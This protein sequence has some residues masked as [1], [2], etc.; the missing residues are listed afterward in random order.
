MYVW[1]WKRPRHRFTVEA[2]TGAASSRGTLL[3]AALLGSDS[4]AAE[5][6]VEEPKPASN[7]LRA[8]SCVRRM[9]EGSDVSLASRCRG[10]DSGR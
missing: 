2:G 8:T 1:S 5:P 9:Q 6:P 10:Q 4:S 7:R 3:A